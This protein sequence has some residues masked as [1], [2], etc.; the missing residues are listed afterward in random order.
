MHM[1]KKLLLPL[2][3][4]FFSNLLFAQGLTIMPDGGNK[5]AAVTERIGVVA[6]HGDDLAPARRE[7]E[8]AIRL[9][10][11]ARVMVRRRSVRLLHGV[12]CARRGA[13][14]QALGE[15]VQPAARP[16]AAHT[17]HSSGRRGVRLEN[18]RTGR[19]TRPAGRT[20]FPTIPSL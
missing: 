13:T 6:A 19:K 4:L 10:Q 11:R 15:R 3:F 12:S 1:K 14:L 17:R 20:D 18:Q 2:L 9:A 7:R 16:A 8:V 5:K